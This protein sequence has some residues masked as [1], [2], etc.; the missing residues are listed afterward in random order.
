MHCRNATQFRIDLRNER[1]ELQLFGELPRIK[2]SNR[3]RLNFCGIDLRV[4]NRLLSS[5]NDEVPDRFPFLFQVALK[6]SPPSAENVHVVQD[7]KSTRLNSSHGS[8]S[9]A[10]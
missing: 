1:A 9:Y 2:I 10:V 4:L 8:I 5:F 3:A 6:I 7:R